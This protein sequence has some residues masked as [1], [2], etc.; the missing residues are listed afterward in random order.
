MIHAGESIG[1]LEPIKNITERAK[2]IESS[3]VVNFI[4]NKRVLAEYN[5]QIK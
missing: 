3:K 5:K 1:T 2:Y 4:D